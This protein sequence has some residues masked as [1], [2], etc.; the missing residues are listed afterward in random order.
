MS[1]SEM[2]LTVSNLPFH[3]IPNPA[4]GLYF[5]SIW[6]P[7]LSIP[8]HPRTSEWSL[9]A[10]LPPWLPAIFLHYGWII[11][12]QEKALWGAG[13]RLWDEL[14]WELMTVVN[15]ICCSTYEIQFFGLLFPIETESR[16]HKLVFSQREIGRE[17]IIFWD[18]CL[19]PHLMFY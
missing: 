2:K 3:T 4:Q 13:L 10:L 17:K 11:S 12:R 7:G 19:P 16:P 15:P 8:I 14:P 1:L 18:R 9:W 5:Q 6:S